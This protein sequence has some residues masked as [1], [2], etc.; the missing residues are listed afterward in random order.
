MPISSLEAGFPGKESKDL[1]GDEGSE[2]NSSCWANFPPAEAPGALVDRDW[3]IG[4]CAPEW[5]CIPCSG[6]TGREGLPGTLGV[7]SGKV[8]QIVTLILNS[9][10]AVS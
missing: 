5:S 4:W 8:L 9:L 6:F 2:Q 1:N 3:V 7:P 10:R